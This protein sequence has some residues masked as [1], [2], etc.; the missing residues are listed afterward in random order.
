MSLRVH[1]GA[2]VVYAKVAYDVPVLA[3]VEWRT[4]RR[5]RTMSTR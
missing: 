3:V 1:G 2:A 5:C 4:A